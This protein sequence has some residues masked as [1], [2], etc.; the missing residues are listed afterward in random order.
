MSSN[1]SLVDRHG[2]ATQKLILGSAIERL[3]K[4]SIHNLTVRVVARHAHISE[5]TIFR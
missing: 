2:S 4:F 5:R 3:E 1:A